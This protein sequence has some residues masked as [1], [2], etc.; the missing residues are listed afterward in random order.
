MEENITMT[1]KKSE[2]MAIKMGIDLLKQG[3]ENGLFNDNDNVTALLLN[4]VTKEVDLDR[5][6]KDIHT[7]ILKDS[8]LKY[9]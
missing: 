7:A 1:F 5:V 8:F 4:L 3:K 6:G 2:W 9:S